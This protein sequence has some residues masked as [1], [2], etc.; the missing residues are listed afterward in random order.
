MEGRLPVQILWRGH[1]YDWSWKSCR[2]LDQ[3]IDVL[4]QHN[5]AENSTRVG[6]ILSCTYIFTDNGF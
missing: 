1:D 3:Q 5:R 2:E 4:G 6:R